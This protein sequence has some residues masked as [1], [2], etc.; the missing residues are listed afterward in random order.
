MFP[1]NGNLQKR[2]YLPDGYNLPGEYSYMFDHPFPPK[3]PAVTITESTDRIY[4]V[5][6]P[7]LQWW[8][9]V[10]RLG[11]HYQWVFYDAV[12]QELDQVVD[13]RATGPATV[14]GIDCVEIR[15]EEI[16]RDDDFPVT[17]DPGYMYAVLDDDRARWLSVIMT[18]NGKQVQ[19]TIGEGD[20]AEQWGEVGRR[21]LV[22]DGRYARQVDGSYV[23]TDR[24]GLGAGTYDVT[25]GEN[26]FHCLRV[27]DREIINSDGGE[28]VEAYLNQAGRTV[29]HRRYDSQYFR[30]G[31]LASKWPDNH[32]MVIDDMVWV[33]HDCTMRAHDIITARALEP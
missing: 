10:P 14:K 23:T 26:T 9:A 1:G 2:V 17:M 19:T 4:E 12:T 7:E 32:K 30:K 15:L 5:D 29:Y 6:C 33:H 22:D 18:V 13:M 27:L 25:I 8:F 3:R 16:T 31:D 28:L 24:S 20:F 21:K 11:E